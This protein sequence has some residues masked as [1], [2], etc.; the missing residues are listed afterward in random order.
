MPWIHLKW[1]TFLSLR[2]GQGLSADEGS[3][4]EPNNTQVTNSVPGA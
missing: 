1:F 2:R 3:I 4:A